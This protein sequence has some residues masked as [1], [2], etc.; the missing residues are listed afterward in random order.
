MSIPASKVVQHRRSSLHT[1]RSARQLLLPLTIFLVGVLLWRFA[2][3]DADQSTTQDGDDTLSTAG[4]LNGLGIEVVEKPPQC[5]KKS[6]NGNMLKVH[7]TGYFANGTEF[8]TRS[9]LNADCVLTPIA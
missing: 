5:E 6:Q 9:D 2:V 8:D 3:A 4:D 7:Y 1:D